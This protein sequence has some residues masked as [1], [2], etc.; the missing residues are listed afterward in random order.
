MKKMRKNY[1]QKPK[2]ALKI[3]GYP[4]KPNKNLNQWKD[5]FKNNV[6]VQRFHFMLFLSKA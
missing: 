1:L 2:K 5:D 3:Y 4:G 6:P